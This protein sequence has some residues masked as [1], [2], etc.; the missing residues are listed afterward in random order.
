METK[1]CIINT[2]MADLSYNMEN[3]ERLSELI[4]ADK[5]KIE[6]AIAILR[7][8]RAKLMAILTEQL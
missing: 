1:V 3:I 2:V 6:A 5:E 8:N 7:D 4:Q